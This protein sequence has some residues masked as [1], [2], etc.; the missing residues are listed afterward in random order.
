MTSI[1]L[2]ELL[3]MH[4]QQTGQKQKTYPSTVST[5]HLTI[6]YATDR[7]GQLPK[8]LHGDKFLPVITDILLKF[9][10]VVPMPKT[11]SSH[12]SSLITDN[13]EIVYRI[14]SQGLTDKGTQFFKSGL[15][16]AMCFSRYKYTSFT[17]SHP[18]TIGQAERSNNILITT[19]RNLV[20][21]RQ[22]YWDTYLQP[23]TPAYNA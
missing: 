6:I 4:P 18:K 1:R 13:S 5:N 8:T 2:E 16:N 9:S 23:F 17:A 15:W 7:L 20:S 19:L 21:K 22:G 14:P 10:K 3:W 11:T 12:I